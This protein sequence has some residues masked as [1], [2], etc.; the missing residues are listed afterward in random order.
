MAAEHTVHQLP[1][2]LSTIGAKTVWDVDSQSL[3]YVDINVAAIRRYDYAEN[4]TY[5]CT[6]GNCSFDFVH[7]CSQHVNVFSVLPKR[8]R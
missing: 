7:V 6:I 2:P 1:S 4:K 3:Y 5:S 8:W